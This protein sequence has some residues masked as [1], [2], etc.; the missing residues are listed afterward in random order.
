M[1]VTMENAALPEAEVIIRGSVTDPE[2][3][4]LLQHLSRRSGSGKLLLYKEDEQFLLD[5]EEIL[6]LEASGSKVWA[7]TKH[8]TYEARLKLYEVKELLS[9]RAFAQI[10]KSTIV[11]MNYVKSIQA[12]FSGNYCL[13]LKERKEVLTISRKYFKE[14]KEKI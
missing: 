6:F 11:N 4:S 7:H 8:D 10:S 12:E 5:A 9:A 13:K 1:K 14:F 3:I 2:V